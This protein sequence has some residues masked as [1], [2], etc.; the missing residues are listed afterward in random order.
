MDTVLCWGSRCIDDINGL[1][2][3]KLPL[4]AVRK[5]IIIIYAVCDVTVLLCLKK[6]DTCLYRV[7]SARHDGDKVPLVYRNLSDK[8]TPSSLVNHLR[9]LFFILG[10][11]A[12]NQRSPLRTIKNIPALRLSK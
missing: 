12:Y 11:V 7:N 3:M 9:T 4:L 6:H 2:H 5:T 10:I 8:L 1:L